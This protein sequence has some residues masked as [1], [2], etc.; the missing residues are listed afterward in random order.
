[1]VVAVIIGILAS[2]AAPQYI[3]AVE[4]SRFG[5]SRIWL[6]SLA[7][8]QERFLSRNDV[9]YFGAVGPLTFDVNLGLLRNFTAENVLGAGTA[10]TLTLRRRAPCPARYGCYG[11]TYTAATR[12]ITCSDPNCTAELLP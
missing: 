4:K 8:A 12:A 7:G 5:E 3:A 11:V 9:Y 2:I 6:L 1:M 10:W